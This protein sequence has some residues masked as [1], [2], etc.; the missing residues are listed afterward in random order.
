M[1]THRWIATLLTAAGAECHTLLT[2][3]RCHTL[4]TDLTWCS[5]GEGAVALHTAFSWR[6][7][8]YVKVQTSESLSFNGRLEDIYAQWS[9]VELEETVCAALSA[10]YMHAGD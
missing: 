3:L 8:R 1:Q 10:L 2:D 9:Y 6:G 5:S 4:L 7:F